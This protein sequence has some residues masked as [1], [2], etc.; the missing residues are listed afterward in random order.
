MRV[1]SSGS[2]PCASRM[3]TAPRSPWPAARCH[4]PIALVGALLEAGADP[5][6]QGTPPSPDEPPRWGS[7][8][9]CPAIVAVRS[10]PRCGTP[11]R[12][13]D[14]ARRRRVS[15]ERPSSA[16]YR[17]RLATSGKGYGVGVATTRHRCTGLPSMVMPECLPP[18]AGVATTLC[19]PDGTFTL[20]PQFGQVSAYTPATVSTLATIA[21]SE[22]PGSNARTT[23]ARAPR[24]SASAAGPSG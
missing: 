8:R 4:S 5:H 10:C 11:R 22:S 21:R 1:I 16:R 19:G 7:P 6:M 12:G 24:R 20:A 14:S 17:A 15:P 2:A 3:S 23:R 9:G 13:G 18:G